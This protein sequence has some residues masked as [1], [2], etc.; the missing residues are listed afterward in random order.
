MFRLVRHPICLLL[1]AEIAKRQLS[2]E[3]IEVVETMALPLIKEVLLVLLTAAAQ[4]GGMSRRIANEAIARSNHSKLLG[5]QEIP[6]PK[7]FYYYLKITE[8]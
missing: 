7:Y 1:G 4:K 6:S 5:E 3:I 8:L 2:A